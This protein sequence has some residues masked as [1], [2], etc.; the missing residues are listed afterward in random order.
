MRCAKGVFFLVAAGLAAVATAADAVRLEPANPVVGVPCAFVFSFDAANDKETFQ[1]QKVELFPDDVR[2]SLEPLTEMVEPYADGTY[3]LAVRFVR[4]C[5]NT[6]ARAVVSGMRTTRRGGGSFQMT[7]SSSF[8]KTLPPLPLNVLPLPERNRPK[9]FSGAVGPTFRLKQTLSAT[10]VC[11]GDLVTA[12]Y[13]LLYDGYLPSNAWPQVERLSKEFKAYDLKEVSRTAKSAT[14]TQVLVPRTTA[15]T[16][17]PLVSFYF[18]NS[19]TR[20]YEVTRAYPKK[21]AFVSDRAASTQNTAVLMNAADAAPAAT[22]AAA[23]AA[24][25]VLRLAP[26]DASPVVVTLPPGTPVKELARG[27]NGWRRLETARG[28][29]WSR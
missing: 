16:N 15:A 20:R 23:P 22:E 2:M 28:I 13:T 10:N 17:T 7:T 26:A 19:Q 5:T 14:W 24:S 6:A 27:A 25:L 1:I 3:R 29:G 4:P 12:T 8:R 9:D 21:L 18:F 11:P